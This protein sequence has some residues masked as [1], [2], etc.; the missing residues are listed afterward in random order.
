MMEE[1]REILKD[2]FNDE[3]TVK[4]IASNFLVFGIETGSAESNALS[5]EFEIKE[6][7]FFGTIICK[8][9]TKYDLI[10]K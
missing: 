7:P 9:D 1:I 4:M 8:S 5:A 6:I 3:E 10:D 2:L